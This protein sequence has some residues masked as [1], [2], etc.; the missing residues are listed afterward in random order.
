MNVPENHYQRR[1]SNQVDAV[2]QIEVES[3]A[4]RSVGASRF[5]QAAVKTKEAS[6]D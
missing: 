5:A 2:A 1:P 4:W 6:H 3:G